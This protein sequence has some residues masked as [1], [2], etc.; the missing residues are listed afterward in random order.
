MRAITVFILLG[1]ICSYPGIG[2]AG[3]ILLPR[4][5]QTVSYAGGDDGAIQKGVVWPVPRFSDNG[6]GTVSDNL[7][8]L[9]W[10]KNA[11]CFD[12]RTWTAALTS[13]NTLASGACG[14]TDGSAAG[15]WALPNAEQLASLTDLSKANPAL[16]GGHPFSGVQ[17]NN[18][19]WSSASFISTPA[20]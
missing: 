5:G 15:D 10:L 18:W 6:D 1:L 16:P 20:N 19:Y 3:A 11:N 8:G 7:T 4:T 2:L 17:T 13:A 14:L 9:I 12:T